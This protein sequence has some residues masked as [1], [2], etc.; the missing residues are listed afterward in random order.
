LAT[1]ARADVRGAGTPGALIR[2]VQV[3][4]AISEW[5]GR[6]FAWLVIPLVASLTY[7]VLARYVFGAPT[8]W[9]YDLSYMLYG[10]H[11]MLGAG[12]TLLKGGHIRTDIFYQNWSPRTQGKVDALLYLLLFFPGMLFFF[13]MGGQEFWQA[14]SIGE[15]SDASPWRPILYPLKATLPLG[16]LLLLVQGV[17]EFI[18]SG[19]LALHGRPL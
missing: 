8:I 16:A 7:E 18:K 2:I 17:S 15:R 10:A 11:F 14:W 1:S 19:H 3:I 4:D 6:V 13:W 12:Y 5:S 9:A